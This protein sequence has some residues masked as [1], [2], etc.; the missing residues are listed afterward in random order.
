MNTDILLW[1]FL[2]FICVMFVYSISMSEHE[3]TCDG[4]NCDSCP[5]L[6]PRCEILAQLG[7]IGVHIQVAIEVVQGFC[8]QE[9]EEG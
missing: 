2:A 4:Q 6:L 9:K 8:L 7:T 1:N 5:Y 3:K